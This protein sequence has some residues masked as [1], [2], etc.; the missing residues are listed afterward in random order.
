MFE[1]RA[2]CVRDAC[3]TRLR[4]SDTFERYLGPE[5]YH[6]LILLSLFIF[7]VGFVATDKVCF[8]ENGEY[9]HAN[10]ILCCDICSLETFGV[11]NG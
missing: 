7:I 5:L 3:R 9:W 10:I 4:V 2:R 6:I 8:G 11:N 1:T